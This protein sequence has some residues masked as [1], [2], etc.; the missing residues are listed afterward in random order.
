MKGLYVNVR[1]SNLVRQWIVATFGTDIVKPA[2]GSVL[3]AIVKP[4][5]ELDPY[6]SPMDDYI[7]EDQLIRIELPYISQR[8]HSLNDNKTYHCNTFFRNHLSLKGQ[9]AVRRHFDKTFKHAFH[10]YMDGYS[11]AVEDT[12]VK[13]GVVSF[14]CEYNLDFTERDIS[15]YTRDWFRYRN[16][17]YQSRIMPLIY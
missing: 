5:H 15:S 8:V 14:F 1:V 2:K 4:Y 11:D 6:E 7:P 10:V 16:K 17:K 13:E 12:K 9:A 3:I